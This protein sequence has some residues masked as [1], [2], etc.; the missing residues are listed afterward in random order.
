MK[1]YLTTGFE[2]DEFKKDLPPCESSF[3]IEELSEIVD[4]YRIQGEEI[5]PNLLEA[6][7]KALE[8]INKAYDKEPIFLQELGIDDDLIISLEEA[9]KSTG[10]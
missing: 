4:Q 9:I 5:I 8:A 3:D 2:N 6:L 10:Q 1:L 7:K